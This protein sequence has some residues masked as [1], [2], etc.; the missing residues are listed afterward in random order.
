MSSSKSLKKYIAQ[1]TK[2]P[3]FVILSDEMFA[4]FLGVPV[5]RLRLGGYPRTGVE[6][7]QN[8]QLPRVQ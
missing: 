8:K 2:T 4:S 5:P 7:I 6:L 3:Q 1:P